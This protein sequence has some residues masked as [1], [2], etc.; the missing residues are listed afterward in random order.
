VIICFDADARTN[1][2]VL[3]AMTRL[4]NW[5]KSQG[6]VKIGYLIVPAETRGKPVKGAD[7]FFAAG[8]TLEELKAAAT[9]APPPETGDDT[10]SDARLAE[11]I[12]DEVLTDQFIW[13]ARCSP[14][15]SIRPTTASLRGL[16]VRTAI[17]WMR[18]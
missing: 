5:L 11:T 15:P 9:P 12:A 13:T 14:R 18:W 7:D 2:N 6:A 1:P 3:R 17:L 4:G 10:F 16:W 8:G